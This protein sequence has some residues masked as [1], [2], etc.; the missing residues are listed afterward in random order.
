MQGDFLQP[1]P[2]L[3]A[4]SEPKQAEAD[5]PI[6]PVT[7]QSEYF[8]AESLPIA[9]SDPPGKHFYGTDQKQLAAVFERPAGSPAQIFRCTAFLLPGTGK[10]PAWKT[11][12]KIG[13]IGN[14]AGKASGGNQRRQLPQIGADTFH[15]G[16]QSVAPDVFTGGGVGKFLPFYACNMAA[17]AVPAQQQSQC[18]ASGAKIQPPVS[19]DVPAE[20]GQHHGVGAQRENTLRQL[21]RKP[22]GKRFHKNLRKSENCVRAAHCGIAPPG[23]LHAA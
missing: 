22:H 13:R 8:C 17:G 5:G 9:R 15:P 7:N 3:S 4:L 10:A 11:A 20:M 14:A 21:Q 6:L 2:R 12:G 18:A 23:S 1:K 19:P 16:V